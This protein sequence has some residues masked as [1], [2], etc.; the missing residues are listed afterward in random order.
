MPSQDPISDAAAPEPAA[1]QSALSNVQAAD[2]TQTTAPDTS[3]AVQQFND[4]FSEAVRLLFAGRWEEMTT[5]FYNGTIALLGD[6]IPRALIAALAFLVLYLIYRS[7][8]SVLTRALDHSKNVEPGLQNL[9]LKTYRV[10]AL[11][12]IGVIVLGQIGVN[13]TTLVAG[14]SIAGIAVGFAARDSL[15]NFISGVTILMDKPFRVGDHIE[16]GEEFGEVDEITLRSTRLRTV[17]NEILVIPNTEMIKQLLINH[18]KRNTLRV[19]IEFGI[20][21]KEKPAEARQ[22]LV[23]LPEGDERI[24]ATPEPSVVVTALADSSV[25]MALRFYLRDPKQ[26]IPVR[27]EY[28]EKV[29]EALREAD[30]EIP[31]P[32]LQLFI[33]EAKAFADAPF[34]QPGE[35]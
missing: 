10:A 11:V 28:T 35:A 4:A 20:A 21:Y 32:H 23:G 18:T 12:F 27:W 3:S 15:E 22:V 1:P 8:N 33:D 5:Q 6:F 25:N 7:V 34:V 9:L 14:L 24:L 2:T 17:R 16:I 13:V 30:I 26:E 29:R 31:F 19:D